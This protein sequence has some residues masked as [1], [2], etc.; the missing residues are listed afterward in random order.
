MRA[1]DEERLFRVP[2]GDG[3]LE[4]MVQPW[5]ALDVVDPS[6]AARTTYD[7]VIAGI[8][9]PDDA[10]LGRALRAAAKATRSVVIR[11][12]GALVIPA[13][14]EDGEGEAAAD[15]IAGVP[16]VTLVVVAASEAPEAVRVAGLRAAVDIEEALDIAYEH[17]GRPQ[18]ANVALMTR[19]PTG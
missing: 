11:D 4:F 15:A 7:I 12:G 3:E 2:Y 18:R 1:P 9:K 8:G 6:R 16:D 10:D 5:F 13:Q 14:L 17:I 19:R